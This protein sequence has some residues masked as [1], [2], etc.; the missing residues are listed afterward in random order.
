MAA[1]PVQ[2]VK[3]KRSPLPFILLGCFGIL[4]LGGIGFLATGWFVANKI[5]QAGFDPELMRTNPSLAAAKMMA[6]VNPDIEVLNVDEGRGT[7]TVREKSTGKRLTVNLD[8]AKEGRIVFKEE[9]GKG[10]VEIKSE[11]GQVQVRTP[12]GVATYGAASEGPDWLPKYSGAQGQGL[13]SSTGTQGNQGTYTFKTSDSVDQVVAFYVRELPGKG[14]E[15]KRTA[16]HRAGP[17]QLETLT[18][19]GSGRTVNM[20][21]MRSENETVVTA[22]W[23]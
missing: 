14:F 22:T 18:A 2:P 9:G 6:A 7:I 3:S 15:V 5:K 17:V 8:D 19:T 10:E 1:A 16:S 13:Y 20:N 21:V 4:V 12:E 11:G 23:Q